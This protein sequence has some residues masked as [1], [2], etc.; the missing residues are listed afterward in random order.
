MLIPSSSVGEFISDF[1]ILIIIVIVYL[2]GYFDMFSPKGTATLIVWMCVAIALLA[3][4]LSFSL[5]KKKA[6]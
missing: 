1:H 2:K 3:L 4:V 5:R 6:D